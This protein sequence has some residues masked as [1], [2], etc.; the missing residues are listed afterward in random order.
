[1]ATFQNYSATPFDMRDL[2]PNGDLSTQ[3]SSI[4]DTSDPLANTLTVTLS[5]GVVIR[6]TGTGFAVDGA[7][8]ATAGTYTQIEIL[9]S[10][11]VVIGLLSGL[12]APANL[13]DIYSPGTPAGILSLGDGIYGSSGN[14]TLYG[15]AGD[16]LFIA[17]IPGSAGVDQ[18]Y[19][20][21]GSDAFYNYGGTVIT[22]DVI[23]GGAGDFDFILPVLGNVDYSVA[24]LS[25]IEAVGFHVSGNG[26]TATF[27]A[28]QI[29]TGLTAN[30]YMFGALDSDGSSETVVIN[31][32]VAT[33]LDVSAFQF[34][35]G[36]WDTTDLIVINGDGDGENITGTV[37]AD[38]ISAGGG[39]DLTHGGAGNDRFLIAAGDLVATEI[40]DG[41][42]DTDRVEFASGV[43]S[44]VDVTLTNVEQ[45]ALTGTGATTVTLGVAAQAL[46]FTA[47]AG[48]DDTVIFSGDFT[49]GQLDALALADI[50]HVQFVSN[51]NAITANYTARVLREIIIQDTNA[52]DVWETVVHTRDAS[53]VLTKLQ[54]VFDTGI[55]EVINFAGGLKTTTVKTDLPGGPEYTWD[56]QVFTYDPTGTFLASLL[57]TEDNGDTRS[58]TYDN[59]GG[60]LTRYEFTDVSGSNASVESF[61]VDYTTGGLKTG[62]ETV[63]DNGTIATTTYTG[64][65]RSS[66]LQT[67]AGNADDS[68]ATF[69]QHFAANGVDATDQIYTA[70]DTGN[71]NAHNFVAGGTMTGTEFNDSMTGAVGADTFIFAAPNGGNDYIANFE[72]G[73]DRVDLTAYGLGSFAALQA[74]AVANGANGVYLTFGPSNHLAINGL[75]LAN[76][77]A[78]DF[79]L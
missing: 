60:A 32:G 56:T 27:N 1:V 7:G 42:A 68:Y 35:A 29:G 51:G 55:D 28:N 46:L 21:A 10:G 59:V 38:T 37:K 4:L 64:G 78:S 47:S 48:S 11:G 44:L 8:L 74:L 50:D 71:T 49:A 26:V 45:I 53:G 75:S 15:Y 43:H 3:V 30:A 61:A 39:A 22:G 70:D 77:D 18:M 6:Y 31:M 25:S 73:V 40:I 2:W 12:A 52:N 13:A 69:L 76:M 5:D 16:D 41:G 24:T 57:Q 36:R 17:D 62:S 14:D 9:N 19:G 23:D 66:Y 65:V 63:F 58:H 33:T 20:G 34:I 79:L 67:D 54:T 72:N